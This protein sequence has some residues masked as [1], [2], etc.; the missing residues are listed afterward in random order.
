MHWYSV[1]GFKKD[2]I[3]TNKL[4]FGASITFRDLDHG[5][6]DGVMNGDLIL[7]KVT[8]GF[9]KQMMEVKIG[10]TRIFLSH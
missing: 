5:L 10:F 4:P 9:L 2:N 3:K 6:G 8:C 1:T 7:L